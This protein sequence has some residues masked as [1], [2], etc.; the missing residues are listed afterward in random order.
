MSQRKTKKRSLDIFIENNPDCE[1]N[2]ICKKR[3]IDSEL[4]IDKTV[5]KK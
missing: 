4:E 5:A 2:G 1:S 3:K